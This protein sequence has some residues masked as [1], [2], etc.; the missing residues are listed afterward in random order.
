MFHQKVCPDKSFCAEINIP[1]VD[2]IKLFIYDISL[3]YVSVFRRFCVL[4]WFDLA[5]QRN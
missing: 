1:G 2:Q 4:F 5:G 3:S